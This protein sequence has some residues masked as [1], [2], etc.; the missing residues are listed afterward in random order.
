MDLNEKMLQYETDL[1]ELKDTV[2]ILQK[3]IQ[4]IE[5]NQ[6][7][8]KP[9]RTSEPKKRLVVADIISMLIAITILV[10]ISIPIIYYIN[11]G[12]KD[13]SDWAHFFLFFL[14]FQ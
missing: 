11:G 2:A 7:N 1:Q 12:E 4:E 14:H 9:S 13:S 8:T 10:V 6:N 5:V 3:K